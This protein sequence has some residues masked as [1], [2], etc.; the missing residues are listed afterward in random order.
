MKKIVIEA[1]TPWL[2][3]DMSELYVFRWVFLMLILRDIKLRY[4][5]TFLGVTWV[6]L[7]PLLTAALFTLVF[8]HV[9]H[10]SSEGVPYLVFAFCGLVPWL[11]FSQALQRASTCLINDTRLIT[12][13]YFPRIFLPLSA[14]FGVGIDFL[15]ALLILFGLMI[16]YGLA[17][18]SQLLFLPVCILVLFVFS[19]G[20][21]LFFSSIN[22][23]YRDLKHIVPFL[24]QFWMYASP[25][26]YSTGVI[27]PKYHLLYSLNPLVGLID[28]F[29]WS[30]LGLENFPHLSFSIASMTSFFLLVFGTIVFRRIE[31]NFADVI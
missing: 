18:T 8:G 25:L 4:K 19:S 28:G 15:I 31:H 2:Q 13:V 5:Q 27:P 30:L 1:K 26:V 7:Q 17:F 12:K 6:I 10:L 14:T 3:L 29:R 22:V 21:N 23:Y 11:M 9:L 16:F 24:V 20:I